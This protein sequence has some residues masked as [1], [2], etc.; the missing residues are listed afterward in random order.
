[1]RRRR[2]ALTRLAGSVEENREESPALAKPSAMG[3]PK[4]AFRFEGQPLAV[5]AK[6]TDSLTG[7][8]ISYI[9][10]AWDC[11]TWEACYGHDK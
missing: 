3:F 1:M 8:V 11:P 4:P 10:S 2:L 6:P 5:D 7:N 9:V